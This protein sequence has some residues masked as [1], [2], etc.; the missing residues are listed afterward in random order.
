[1]EDF[2]IPLL[3]RM[4]V[5]AAVVLAATLAAERVGPFW[6]ALIGAFPTSAGPAYVMLALKE[7]AAFVSASAISSLAGMAAIAPFVVA[8]IYLAPRTNVLF[9]LVGALVIWAVFAFPISQIAW[10]PMTA[11]VANVIVYA[12]GFWL[13]GK[14]IFEM[15]EW[16]TTRPSWIELLL[17]AFAVGLFVAA[18]VTLSDALGTIGTGMGA[19]FPIVLISLTVI[20][21][22]RLGGVAVALTMK[23]TLR[24]VSVMILALLM[25]HYGVQ[26]WG[27]TLG[28]CAALLVSII[29]ATMFIVLNRRNAAA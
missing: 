12:I 1:M 5:T 21:H 3:I 16:P 8:L 9:T 27:K 25:V 28:L 19:V 29:W 26:W 14:M 18:V 6:A 7:D 17:R 15:E 4:V 20:L 23:G 22:L 13:T 11:T 10:T 2:W 24:V